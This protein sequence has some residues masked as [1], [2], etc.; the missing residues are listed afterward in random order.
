MARTKQQT[1]AKIIDNKTFANDLVIKIGDESLTVGELR[2]MDAETDGQSTKDLEAREGNL[3]RAQAHLAETLQAVAERTGIPLETLLDGKLDS[4]VP[5]RGKGGE[6][7]DDPDAVLKDIDPAVIKA[8]EKKFGAGAVGTELAAL[9]KELGDTK[10]ALGIALKINM[11]DHYER[12]FR[13]LAGDIPRGDD[14]KPLVELDLSK[15]LKYADDNG[16]KDKTGRY[17]LRRAVRDLTAE[18]RYQRDLK[19]AEDRGE[20]RGL[21]KATLANVPKPGG[22]HPAQAKPPVDAKGRVKTLDAVMQDA[23]G[24]V[25]IQR[26]IAGVPGGA[27]A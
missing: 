5:V 17:D 24:D 3:I 4:I 11:D 22:I 1:L 23:L 14:G 9:K 2:A 25:E 8:L 27:A 13:D 12:T 15:A 19:A 21:E 10:K 26:M 20:K 6:N 16:I 7:D 18:A